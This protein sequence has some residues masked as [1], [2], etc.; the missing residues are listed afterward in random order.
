MEERD[1]KLDS[2]IDR[3]PGLTIKVNFTFLAWCL[4]LLLISC[5]NSEKVVIETA[6]LKIIIDENFASKIIHTKLATPLIQNFSDSENLLLF[7]KKTLHFHVDH[8]SVKKENQGSAYE[9]IG[10]SREGIEKKMTIR[11]YNHFPSMAT[12]E[13]VYTNK[14]DKTLDVLGWYNH[15]YELSPNGDV[16]SFY[17]FQGSS[18]SARENWILP[19]DS[20]FYKENFMGM[21]ASDYGGGIPITD[22]W[23]KDG[24]IAIGHVALVPK[25]VALPVKKERYDPQVTIAVEKKQEKPITF[26]PG[27]SISTLPTFCA[28]H[29]GD[30]FQTLRLFSSFMQ[31]KGI[32]MKASPPSAYEAMWCAWGYERNFTL[33][34][35]KGTLPKVKELGIKWVTLDDGYQITEGDWQLNKTKFPNGN[36]DMKKLVDAIHDLQLKAQLWWAPL[37]VA[38]ESQLY[39]AHPKVLLKTEEQAPQF[40]TWWDAWYMAP[41][42]STVRQH[43]ADMVKMFIHDWNFDGLKLDGQHMNAVPPDYGEN[44]N[45]TDAEQA[46]EQLPS[47]FHLINTTASSYKKDALIQHCPCGTCMSFYHLPTT[48][49]TVASDPIGSIQIRQKGKVYKAIAPMIAYFGDHV[50]LSDKGSDFASSFGVGAVL[51]TKFTW[52]KDNASVKAPG[53][54]L[55]PEKEKLWKHWFD[56]YHQLMLSKGKYL[57][58]LYDIGFDR[59]ETHVISKDKVFYYAFYADTWS[60]PIYLK[61]L[62][63]SKAYAVRDYFNNKNFGTVNGKS[64][65]I[66]GDFVQFLL[67]EVK[68]VK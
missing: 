25:L 15:K 7:S 63:P 45:I 5:H 49:Q 64:P 23:R 43:T 31:D 67:L 37:A 34:E 2:T 20:F 33:Q 60:G 50:E 29:Q 30:C 3:L 61:G 41:T 66:E 10:S 55:T 9:I 35:I 11:V 62:D 46:C 19:I 1:I 38:P 39:K 28:V 48:N 32:A 44:H 8:T 24:G 12:Y 27:Q 26:A 22:I 36:V 42:D 16:P 58:E 40:I 13:V 6:S 14:G 18:S 54:V 4:A 47:F 53:F 68:E 65:K 56:L 51:G 17:S 21:N 52:P 57:G 59:P